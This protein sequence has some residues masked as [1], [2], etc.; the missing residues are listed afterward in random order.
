VDAKAMKPRILV[1]TKLFWSEGGG[2]ELATYL[3]VKDILSKHF[4]VTIVSGTRSPEPDILKHAK[5]IHW[6]TLEARYKPIEWI[7]TFANI[8]WVRNLVEKADIV[9]IP[10]HTLIP[11]TIAVKTI[12]PRT[13]I[14]LHLHNYQLLT[15]TS[16]VLANREPDMATDIIIELGEHKSLLRALLTGFGHYINY[17]NRFAAMLADKIICVSH[18]Q[19]EIIL[20]HV[21]EIKNKAEVIYNPPPPIPTINKRVSDEP[22][23]IYAGGASYIKG[24]QILIKALT[25][26]L[27]KHEAKAYIILGKAS[28][29]EK[30]LVMKLAKEVNGR[31]IPLDKLPHN[32]YLKLHEHAWTLLLPS[33]SEEPLPYAIVEALFTRTIPIASR[34][35]GIPEII[36]GSPAEEYLFTLGDIN[37][38]V[39]RVEKLLS[40]SKKDIIDIGIRLREHI[41]R[42]LNEER[43]ESKLVSLFKS[44]I[45]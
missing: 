11:L 33:I 6:S 37:E 23:L 5:Y 39:D 24:F 16:V 43:I 31:L 42:L 20:R 27:R 18:R 28:P 34:V 2:A 19:C 32:E 13:K 44:L 45:S 3:V 29:K 26:I 35:G 38:F 14:V 8:G 1:L 25:K 22:S 30:A 40:Q 4:D 9:Y 41:L 12:N 10:S 7:K 36:E 21:P 17:V 15:Y